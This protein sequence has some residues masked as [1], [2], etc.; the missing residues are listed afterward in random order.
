[1][2]LEFSPEKKKEVE[3]TL[4]RYPNKQAAMLPVLHIAQYQFGHISHE[5]MELVARTLELPVTRVQD[6][7]TFYTMFHEKPV[8]KFHIQVCHTLSCAIR[9]GSQVVD[10]LENKCGVK[11]DDGISK[12]GKFSITKVECLGSCGTAPMMQVNDDY[13]ENLTKTKIDQLVNK[14]KNE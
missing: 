4:T 6:V 2:A 13:Y 10:Y 8:G 11:C 14:W 12:D 1:M 7:V 9:G 5:V 3:W